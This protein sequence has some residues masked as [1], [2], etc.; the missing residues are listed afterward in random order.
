[1]KEALL[2]KGTLA[3]LVL[4]IVDLSLLKDINNFVSNLPQDETI[5]VLIN[6]AGALINDRKETVEGIEASFALNTL[7]TYQLTELLIPFLKKSKDG[8]VITVSSGGM[9]NATLSTSDLESKINYDGP[10][11]Y[12]QQKRAQVEL[13]NYWAREHP[14]IR[15]YSMHPGWVKTPGVAK[16]LPTFSSM[17]NS[18]LRST[19]EGCDTI[20]FAAL[21]GSLQKDKFPSGSF[22]FDRKV[23]PQHISFSNTNLGDKTDNVLKDLLSKLRTFTSRK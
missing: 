9:Y 12:A 16:S 22:I 15:F 4:K 10:T 13:T 3:E 14:L 5:D 21:S 17:M 18:S 2:K 23:A 7:G 11:A 8:R 1:M 6:N 19:Q 20:L